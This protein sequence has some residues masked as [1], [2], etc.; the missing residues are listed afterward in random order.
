M[1]V[2]ANS[3]RVISCLPRTPA[4]TIEAHCQDVRSACRPSGATVLFTSSVFNLPLVTMVR[5]AGWPKGLARGWKPPAS[6]R[7]RPWA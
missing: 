5:P 7:E 2:T 1:A 4:H 6:M 3:P